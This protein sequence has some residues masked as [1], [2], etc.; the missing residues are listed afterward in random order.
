MLRTASSLYTREPEVVH[1]PLPP[2]CKGRWLAVRRDGGVVA[3]RFST[4]FP[5]RL[6]RAADSRPYMLR[7]KTLRRRGRFY[8]GPANVGQPL[9]VAGAWPR[10]ASLGLRPIHL[11]VNR[12]YNSVAGYKLGPLPEGA[13]SEADWGSFLKTLPPSSAYAESTSLGEGGFLLKKEPSPEGL[14]S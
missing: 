1:S 7:A 3:S 5:A 12:P 10:P 13:V 9:W 8:I 14:G 4:A 6:R 11:L 2:L